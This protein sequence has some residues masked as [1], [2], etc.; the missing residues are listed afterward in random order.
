MTRIL[1]GEFLAQFWPKVT[2]RRVWNLGLFSMPATA[3]AGGCGVTRSQ[4]S[5]P[6]VAL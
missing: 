2:T 1:V 4:R 5:R 3:L 6:E